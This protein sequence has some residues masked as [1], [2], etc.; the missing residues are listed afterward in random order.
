MK[1]MPFRAV[2]PNLD[3][4]PHS[5]D[6]FDTV[7]YRYHEY[8]AEGLFQ[9]TEPE[10]MY[11]YQI[12]EAN[13][14]KRNGLVVTTDIAEY[15]N[16][17]LKP[18]EKTIVTNE[19]LQSELLHTRGAAIKPILLSYSP[20]PELNELIANYIETHKKFYVIELGLEKHRFWQITEGGV[21]DKIRQIFDEKIPYA[22]IADGHH[23]SASFASLH[24]MS[25]NDKT[26]KMLSA[27]FAEN[28]LKI[29]AFHRVV[30]DL[31]GLS[32]DDFLEKL[33]H[34][35]KIKIIRLATLPYARFEMTMFLEDKWF[36]LYWRKDFLKQFSDASPEGLVL[37]DV[38]LLNEKILKPILGIKNIR[39][40]SRL[41]CIDGQQGFE[42]V[43]KTAGT[44][45]VGFCLLPIE[46]DDLKAVVDS[47]GT[48]PPK[49]T[50]FEP[51]MK[52]GLLV[53]EI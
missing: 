18:H 39:S 1:I 40:D 8:A 20:I 4:V 7:K 14:Q 42:K 44:E 45:G 28:T 53:Y 17:N 35:F 25:P 12:K 51:R 27:Y 3:K 19:D 43:A 31:N 32:S 36:Q 52:N 13:G 10:A 9:S 34:I 5:N 22:Y 30:L 50:F 48:L 11:I 15:F 29:D 23:R 47:H 16:G 24:K 2:A 49:S 33:K 37:L 26:S 6:F 38:D 46:W 41:K 21:I